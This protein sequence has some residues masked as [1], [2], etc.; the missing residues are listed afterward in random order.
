MSEG[1]ANKGSGRVQLILFSALSL[2][3]T[4]PNE[5]NKRLYKLSDLNPDE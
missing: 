2:S 4:L 3:D 5:S 1:N